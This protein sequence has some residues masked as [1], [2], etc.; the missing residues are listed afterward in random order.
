M[1][2]YYK[3]DDYYYIEYQNY[4]WKHYKLSIAENKQEK[5]DY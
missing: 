5:Y 2:L 3:D 1:T 4:E